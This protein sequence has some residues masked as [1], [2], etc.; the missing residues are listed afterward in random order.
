MCHKSDVPWTIPSY[1]QISTLLLSRPRSWRLRAF[2][3]LC[4]LYTMSSRFSRCWAYRSTTPNTLVLNCS[5]IILVFPHSW[6][7]VLGKISLE[8]LAQIGVFILMQLAGWP[9]MYSCWPR[10]VICVPDQWARM[11]SLREEL[12]W[13]KPVLTVTSH[14]WSTREGQQWSTRHFN[15][16]QAI[17]IFDEHLD[18]S[19]FKLRL[20]SVFAIWIVHWTRWR[21]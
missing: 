10:K 14:L 5:N 15:Q 18:T 12:Y 9:G 11:Q 4:L 17:S 20:I 2:W 13:P 21:Y 19:E 7:E 3:K 8:W 16:P 6:F 1:L